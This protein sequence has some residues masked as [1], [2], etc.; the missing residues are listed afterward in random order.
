MAPGQGT[1]GEG[2][3]LVSSGGV[4]FKRDKNR[5][6]ICIIAKRG[7]KI[8]AIPRGRVEGLETPEVTAI[9]E[10]REE[11]GFY[12][13]IL[14]KI[15][16]TYFQFYSRSDHCIVNR[17][18][19]FF[20]MES[21]EGDINVRDQEADAVYWCSIDEAMNLLKY[22]NERAILVKAQELLQK[23]FG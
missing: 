12:A 2:V 22:D 3:Q 7:M 9:R 6:K 19:H 16:E 10:V 21:L 14:E 5:T 20:L 1:P 8:W 4:L 18:V 11:T 15:G 23:R 17:T 13:K